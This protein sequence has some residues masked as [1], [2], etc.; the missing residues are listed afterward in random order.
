MILFKQD[1]GFTLI[2]LLVVI[3]IIGILAS[4][5]LASLSDARAEARDSQRLSE[6]KELMKALEVYRLKNAQYPCSGP[7]GMAA[8][9]DCTTTNGA[10]HLDIKTTSVSSTLGIFSAALNGF[11]PTIDSTASIR[12]F[13]RSK[14]NNTNSPDPSGY[15]IYVGSE[16]TDY[17]GDGSTNELG[18]A[19]PKDYCKIVVGSGSLDLR[20]STTPACPIQGIQ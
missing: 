15:V 6:A 12:Y 5:V 16:T 2:E 14:T 10:L 1:K 9:T 17:D 11:L 4:T 18:V 13:V 19:S 8:V 3:A 20:A 7:S